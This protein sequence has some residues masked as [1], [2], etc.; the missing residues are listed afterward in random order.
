M[1]KNALGGNVET[2]KASQKEHFNTA[3]WMHGGYSKSTEKKYCKTK[4]A[5]R[6]LPTPNAIHQRARNQRWRVVALNARWCPT[7]HGHGAMGRGARLSMLS[8]CT[9]TLRARWN[10]MAS[11]ARTDRTNNK[12]LNG[13]NTSRRIK[14]SQTSSN[15]WWKSAQNRRIRW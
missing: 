10:W 8:E 5:R 6:F 14:K 7:R 3:E 13:N 15:L 12:F 1:I 2:L 4:R 9:H 11:G